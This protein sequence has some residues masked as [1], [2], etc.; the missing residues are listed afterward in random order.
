MPVEQCTLET[1]QLAVEVKRRELSSL[2]ARCGPKLHLGGFDDDS[3]EE[4][5]EL[6][7]DLEPGAGDRAQERAGASAFPLGRD[8]SSTLIGQR[9]SG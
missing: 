8:I 1:R 6:A 2:L 5:V 7:R 4:L 9:S 3:A